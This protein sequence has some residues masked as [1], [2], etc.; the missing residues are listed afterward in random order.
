M[1]AVASKGLSH[2]SL[3]FMSKINVILVILNGENHH[4]ILGQKVLNLRRF[5]DR[6]PKKLFC[7][8]ENVSQF[9][10]LES[11]LKKNNSKK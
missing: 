6:K 11:Y 4:A 8:R 3:F 9:R 10:K 1:S 7:Q 2:V 5:I